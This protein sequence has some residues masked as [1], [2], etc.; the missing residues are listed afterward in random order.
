MVL[1]KF[2]AENHFSSAKVIAEKK[3]RKI[4]G[5]RNFCGKLWDRKQRKFNGG[6]RAI[7]I[8]KSNGTI[9][10]ARTIIYI[11]GGGGD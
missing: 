10:S 1:E 5:K 11:L 7:R 9:T 4:I 2:F 3:S 8:K 6:T